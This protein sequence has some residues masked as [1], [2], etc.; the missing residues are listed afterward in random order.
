MLWFLRN[1]L[2]KL[3]SKVG[4]FFSETLDD[5]IVPDECPSFEGGM[6][7]NQAAST[8]AANQAALI[9]NYDITKANELTTRRGTAQVGSTTVKG[10]A[11][12]V[13]RLVRFSTVAGIEQL[14]ASV[15]HINSATRLYK[16]TDGGAWSLASPIPMSLGYCPIVQGINKLYM[17]GS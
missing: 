17:R 1:A 13:I 5:T 4:L 9:Q 3:R 15:N 7:S 2:R 16:Y 8:L 11:S 10:D 12:P 14:V 6:V